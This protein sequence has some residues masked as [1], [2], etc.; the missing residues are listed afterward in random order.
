MNTKHGRHGDPTHF[1]QI[2]M[3]GHGKKHAEGG[4]E[5]GRLGNMPV[6]TSHYKKGGKTHRRSRHAEGE[7]ISPI[8]GTKSDDIIARRKGGRA[9]HAEGDIIAKPY[10]KGGDTHKKRRR[11]AEGGPESEASMEKPMPAKESMLSR[12]GKTHRKRR[13]HDEGDKVE[14]LAAGG[15]GKV[16]KGMLSKSGKII[17]R[18]HN[19]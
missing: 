4:P 10:R 14:A 17:N 11:H 6:N 3:R 5:M 16:R 8:T 15:A 19:I 13:R 7:A 18:T 12:G 1:A 2:F 9:C